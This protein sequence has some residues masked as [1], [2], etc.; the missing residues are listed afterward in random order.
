LAGVDA[1][2]R[3]P[4]GPIAPVLARL[5]P[6]LVTPITLSSAEFDQLIAFLRNALLDPQANPHSLRKLIPA[7]VPSGRPIHVFQ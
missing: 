5:D 4:Q 6:A 3:G 1:D 7:R 2:L